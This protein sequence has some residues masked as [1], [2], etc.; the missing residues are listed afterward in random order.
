MKHLAGHDH[1]MI[2]CETLD[3]TNSPVV[4]SL[5]AIK[6]DI[7][8]VNEKEEFDANNLNHFHIALKFDDQ[9]KKGFDVGSSALAFHL[10][11]C[12]AYLLN[13]I[14]GSDIRLVDTATGLMMFTEFV[15]D[16]NNPMFWTA[17]AINDHVWID[18]LYTAYGLRNPMPYNKRFCFRTIREAFHGMSPRYV[19]DHDSFSDSVN[20][21]IALQQ[22]YKGV[23]GE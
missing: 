15:K 18:N 6:F 19:N 3:I 17:G 9:I 22:I 23:V 5:S 16:F 12:P 1:V 4:F 2:D 13:C 21:A 10:K 14:N 20:Q 7:D 11:T 8:S